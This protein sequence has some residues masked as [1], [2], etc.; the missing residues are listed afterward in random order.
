MTHKKFLHSNI[1]FYSQS[2]FINYF[3]ELRTTDMN[4]YF[5]DDPVNDLSDEYKNVF[6]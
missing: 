1:Q 3:F 4:R 5:S 6:Q 2:K